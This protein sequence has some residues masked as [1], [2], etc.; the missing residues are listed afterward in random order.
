M[1]KLQKVKIGR[2]SVELRPDFNLNTAIQQSHEKAQNLE[3][4]SLN[5]SS[6]EEIF[7]HGE[8][9]TW[10]KIKTL[11]LYYRL[12]AC[13]PTVPATGNRQ[14]SFGATNPPSERWPV[15]QLFWLPEIIGNPLELQTHQVK[16]GKK[17]NNK[18]EGYAF[19]G[20]VNRSITINQNRNLISDSLCARG[21]T[22][23]AANQT[24]LNSNLI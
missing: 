21:M 13:W 19:S 8:D 10:T 22:S 6:D 14:E 17:V 11:D 4:L 9:Q 15:G 12:L 18:Q 7:P 3:N 2:D 1:Q 20:N 16:D 24:K 23:K 5:R